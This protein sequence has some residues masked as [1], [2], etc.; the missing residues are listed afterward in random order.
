MCVPWVDSQLIRLI[1]PAVL[2][3]MLMLSRATGG[4]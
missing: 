2:M 3:L 4:V 1:V